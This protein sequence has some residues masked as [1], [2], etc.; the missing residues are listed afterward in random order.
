MKQNGRTFYKI[1]LA[2]LLLLAP[3][4]AIHHKS[5][6]AQAAAEYKLIWEYSDYKE[7]V[8]C[9][10]Y[11]FKSG[12]NGIIMISDQKDGV[13]AE[14]PL[15]YFSYT[16]GSYAYYVRENALY[17]YRYADKKETWLKRLKTSDDSTFYVSS[18][19][20]G[21][22][23]ITRGSFDKWK[24][25]TYQ[26]NTKTKKLKLAKSNCAILSRYGKY[27][28]SQDEYRTDVSPFPATL[29][30]ITA[31][32][33]SKIKTLTS[34]AHNGVFVKGKLYYTVYGKNKIHK[35]TL[36]RC[37]PNGSGKK[38]IAV[39]TSKNKDNEVLISKITSTY[40]E[41]YKDSETYRY[42]YKN[43]KYKKINS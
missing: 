29:Y 23:F 33:L 25:W 19:Y 16:N 34:Y 31:N 35:A 2:A 30:K 3:C 26:Y 14:T 12:S 17:R 9:G 18:V 10:K 6:K 43:K 21:K 37:N 36:Y 1:F 20:G 41:V 5:T 8:K 42:T 13:Y 7:P 32:G 11:Y 22:V 40:C 39:F 24:H 15:T 38:K 28:V 27:V 4:L